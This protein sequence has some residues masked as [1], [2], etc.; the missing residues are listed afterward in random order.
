[1][2][3]AEASGNLK[4]ATG[5]TK[6]RVRLENCEPKLLQWGK[7]PSQDITGQNGQWAEFELDG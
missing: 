4:P 3:S 5:A 6:S 1:M 7:F 2:V